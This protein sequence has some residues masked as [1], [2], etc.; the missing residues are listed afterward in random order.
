MT[1]LRTISLFNN[2]LTGATPSWPPPLNTLRPAN[3]EQVLPGM[4]TQHV[5]TATTCRHG[6]GSLVG[7]MGAT[8]KGCYAS[9]VC[10]IPVYS[11]FAAAVTV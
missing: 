6:A 2:S 8:A 11:C 9:T 10:C 5:S 7:P 1:S 3:A 4:H